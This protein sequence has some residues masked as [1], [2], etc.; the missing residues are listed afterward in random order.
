MRHPYQVN[1]WFCA[2]YPKCTNR[3]SDLTSGPPKK[4]CGACLKK[5]RLE[6]QRERYQ[7]IRRE[8]ARQKFLQGN[9]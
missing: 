5:Q 6:R 4:W 1:Y 7:A 9:T 8:K 3:L 2:N